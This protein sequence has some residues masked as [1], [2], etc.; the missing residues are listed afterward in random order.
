M[1]NLIGIDLDLLIRNAAFQWLSEKTSMLGEVLPRTLLY[2]GFMFQGE[3]IPLVSPKG[4]FKPRSMELPLTIT[5][6]PE[7]PYSDSF[8]RDGFLS[9]KYRGDNPLHPDNVG[10]RKLI[11]LQ[12]PLIYFHGIVKGKY[13]AVWPVYIVNDDPRQLTFSVAVDQMSEQQVFVKSAASDVLRAYITRGVKQRLH[14]QAFREK[15]L[16]AY[17]YQCSLCRLRHQELLDAAHITPDS[18]PEGEP[19]I[20]NGIALCKLHHAAYDNF[21]IGVSPDYI[22]HVRQDV[23][24]EEDGP[25]LLYGLKEMHG[26]DLIGPR[27]PEL[28]PD[29]GRLDERFQ[30]F[31]AAG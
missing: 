25:M 22:I 15:V 1:A 3:R 26:R 19:V 5:T 12:R 16:R 31:R 20:T 14:Q 6:T 29:K 11:Q 2:E 7:G 18:N 21:I 23:L 8:R 28:W 24:E 17:R 30:L 9:Y 13:L 4:I 27:S 10:L